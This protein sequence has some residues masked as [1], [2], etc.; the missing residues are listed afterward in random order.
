MPINTNL[1]T[2]PYYD[3]FDLE[4]QYYRVLFKP[5]FALQAR[6][7]IQ[8]QSVLQSQIE[9]FGD[10][11]FKEGSIVKGCTFTTLND[12]Q[13]VRVNDDSV[14]FPGTNFDPT[15]YISRRV[16]EDI[17]GGIEAEFD[18]VYQVV[19]GTSG[20][21]ANIVQGARGFENR[22]PELNTLF[23]NYL[24]TSGSNKQFIDGEEL[25]INE[26]K[27]KVGE[28]EPLET[29]PVETNLNVD[30]VNAT[31]L[32]TSTGNSFGI[33]AAPGIIFQK[34]HF[35]FADSQTVVVSK[36]N[37]TP[38]GVNVGYQVNESLVSALQDGSL[39]DNANGSLNE[40]A[41]GADRLKLL[42][43]LV[44]LQAADAEADASF[45]SLIRYKNGAAVT[46][47][48]VSQ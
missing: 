4:N 12:L 37:N 47:R 33:Q 24:N 25:T 8:L 45:F 44:V 9:Q 1:N 21:I 41:P 6:E 3:D 27:Y 23:I 28:L 40:N 43:Q 14:K 15:V 30:R 46:L 18:Y 39:Y 34:G 36:Y 31:S 7:L 10:N 5:G 35:L 38:D 2:A 22:A 19:G 26:Y 17:G 20:L 11:I 48:D 42:P 29:N 13:F 32:L 16:T